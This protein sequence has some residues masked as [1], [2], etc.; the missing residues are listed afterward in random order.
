MK[1]YFTHTTFKD[2]IKRGFHLIGGRAF[3]IGIFAKIVGS[4]FMS[5]IPLQ[6]LGG[7]FKIYQSITQT[8]FFQTYDMQTLLI[9]LILSLVGTLLMVFAEAM[10][11]HFLACEIIGCASVV[12][13]LKYVFNRH[14]IGNWFFVFMITVISGAAFVVGMYILSLLG[15]FGIIVAVL[16]IL[17]IILVMPVLS[18]IMPVIILEQKNGI[19]A[20][21]R[22]LKIG[23]HNYGRILGVVIFNNI[24]S[25][26]PFNPVG[27]GTTMALAVSILGKDHEA[28]MA[29]DIYS[30]FIKQGKVTPFS[31]KDFTDNLP[32]VYDASL[33]PEKGE[34]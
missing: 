18:L 12:G 33:A 24:L 29:F 9:A 11:T 21:P 6:M 25:V 19:S 8:G 32:P 2:Y 27:N 15:I 4:V 14:N 22:V 3:L 13:S 16:I 28:D 30:Y 1:H 20:F 10:Y 7:Y 17:Y 23:Y 31:L 26:I 34:K 5:M